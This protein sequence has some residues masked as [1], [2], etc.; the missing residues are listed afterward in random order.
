[1]AFEAQFAEI[2]Q[3]SCH[4]LSCCCV[5]I[6]CTACSDPCC[7]D[8]HK[9]CCCAGGTTS[10]E[11]CIGE[12]GCWTGFG[13]TCCWIHACSTNNMALGCCN[14]FFMGRPYGGEGR[15]VEDGE[16]A[17]MQDANW[18]CYLLFA[19]W[20]CGPPMPYCFS[21]SKIFCLEEKHTRAPCWSEEG[22]WHHYGKAGCVV[23]RGQL[24]PTRRIGL[25]LCG[26]AVCKK[27]PSQARAS[28]VTPGQQRM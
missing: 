22:I 15:P 3:N 1:M 12:K 24:P 18:C 4:L 27:E 8:K 23:V 2:E 20:A 14:T 28:L 9:L 19:G 11:D 6:S 21:N 26:C 10:G 25:G 5:G 16:A 7:M 13:K 17:F